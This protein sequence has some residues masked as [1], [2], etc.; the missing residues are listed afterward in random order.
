M[1]DNNNNIKDN[2]KYFEVVEYLSLLLVNSFIIVLLVNSCQYL[3]II[4]VCFFQAAVVLILLYGC[5]SWTLTRWMENKL[6]GNYTRMLWAIL[7]KFWRQHP[8]K[9][10]LYGHLPPIMK[11]SKLDEPDMQDTAGEAVTSS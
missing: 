11:L 8:T 1:F 3:T 6:D 4:V 5:T 10:Q 2:L 9:H 7:N